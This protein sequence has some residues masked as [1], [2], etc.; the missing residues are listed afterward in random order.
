MPLVPVTAPPS[1]TPAA[2][3]PRPRH[4]WLWW[5]GGGLV[6]LLV[7][8]VIAAVCALHFVYP[9][10][11]HWAESPAG[12]R[13]ASQGMSKTLKVDGTFAPLR[14][15]GW[16]IDSASFTSTGWPGE[17]IGALN[18]TG[19]Q[20]EFD[21]D[22]VWKGAWRINYVKIDRA[23][24]RLVPPNDKL[25]RPVPPKKPRPWY[26]F[27]LPSRVECGPITCP[28]AE[29]LYYFQGRTARIHDANVE[30]DLIGKDLQ[31]TATSGVLEMPYLPPLRIE[32]L[33]MLV[34]RPLIRVDTAQ[35]AGLDPSDLAR[36][37]LR[38]TI[39]MR[40]NKAIEA[41]GEVTEIPI[42]QI[43]P[44]DLRSVVHG[45]A[46]GRVVWKRDASGQ[47]LD[48]DG[49]LSLDGARLD[50]L[51]VFK[52]L[53]I[54]HGNPDLANF[55][56]DQ[57]ACEFH[58]HGN[59]AQLK[60]NAVSPGK[61]AFDGTVDYDL[62]TRRATVDLAIT[63]LPLKTWLPNE[64][65]P[66]AGGLAQAH[67]Q[68]QGEL[69]TIRNSS[70]HATLSLDGGTIRTPEILRRLLAAKKLRAPD[71]IQFKT[72]EMDLKYND[73]TF[74]LTRGDFDLP[75]ILSAQVSG[76]LLD[77]ADLQAQLDWQGLSIDEWLPP[78]LADE[79]SGAVQGH[80]RMQVERWKLADG[81]YAGQIRLVDGHLSY[82]PFQSLL[83]RFLHDRSLLELPLTRASF[84]WTWSGKRLTVS[85][86]DLATAGNRFG[87]RGDFVVER[88]RQLS[89][90]LWI[91]TRPEYVRRMAGLGDDVF[92]PG[93]D[94][95]R[96]AR[97]SI[98]GTA[99]KPKQDLASQIVGQIGHHPGAIFALGFK[100]ISWYVG[101]WFGAEKDWKRPAAA[102]V[103][104]N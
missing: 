73:K 12:Q 66:G 82:T 93:G 72:A 59:H 49:N 79:F 57:A 13:A 67:L 50:D 18:A 30:A 63:D 61:L 47:Q 90:T 85:Q 48:S 76:R 46:T 33:V 81:S 44:E 24:I 22:A 87:V 36:V 89:G 99:K 23:L 86:L 17:A 96:W 3:V 28:H 11:R 80:A 74:E 58:L 38:G 7:L 25:K 27:F 83:A 97:V 68:W 55:A 9:F 21:P 8:V 10:A 40:E 91:G 35:L 19:I 52:Q 104:V 60:L 78:G 31:Y 53:V 15:D 92:F 102:D 65:K 41:S 88:D 54:L 95:L 37:A 42:E 5:L 70:G 45:R 39:G 51:S 14:V 64:F 29:L 2:T 20:A 75:G 77:G 4:H 16:K 69:R 1:E 43:L 101:N 84:A 56:F 32:R 103:T 94:G 62:T 6:G 26:L 34:T 71:D 98:S 100:G